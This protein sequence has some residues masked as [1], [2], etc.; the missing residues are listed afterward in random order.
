[1]D[2]ATVTHEAWDTVNTL[3]AVLDIEL[4][5]TI[6][7]D[8]THIRYLFRSLIQKAVEHGDTDVTVT[9]GD[10]PTG[11]YVA[12]DG[13]DIPSEERETDI[14]EGYTTAADNG[15]TGLGLAFVQKLAEVYGWDCT[16]TESESGGVR[17]EFRNVAQDRVVSRRN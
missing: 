1:M 6:Q 15:G 10:L 11:F 17:F 12:D 7:A 2:L 4:D 8:K 9:V 5:N 16:V 13:T 14:D 3:D